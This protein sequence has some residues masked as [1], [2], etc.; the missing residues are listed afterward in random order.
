MPRLRDAQTVCGEMSQLSFDLQGPVAKKSTEPD[1]TTVA[2]LTRRI[3]TLLETDFGDLWVEG[4]ISNMRRQSSGHVYFTLKDTTAQLTC[5]LF[6]GQTPQLRGMNFADGVQVQ[7]FG[8]ISVYEPRGQYQMIV[9]K[10]RECGAGALQAKFE[11]LKKRLAAEG[12]FESA[13]KRPLPK[14]PQRIGVVTSATGAAIRDFLNVLHRRHRG[15]EVVIHPVRVQGRGAA[16]EIARAVEEL[17][18]ADFAGAVDVIVVT[19]GGGSL[20][21]LWEF[22]EEVVARAIA[23]S[24]VP[25]VSAI[26]HEI[27]F[28]IS[29]FVA[30][31]R[32]ATPSA[33][34]E[35]LS[36]DRE[37]LIERI[38]AFRARLMR[39][40]ATRV[41]T[42]RDGI[43]TLRRTALFLEPQRALR[44][45]Q[46]TLDRCQEDLSR[47]IASALVDR[48]RHLDRARSV[49]AARSPERHLAKALGQFNLLVARLST[50]YN[51]STT[52]LRVRVDRAKAVLSSL[53]PNAALARGYTVTLDK[54]GRSIRTASELKRGD[55]LVTKFR[56][57]TA[58]SIVT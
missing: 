15:I 51:K 36:A 19:R 47:S 30:D 39:P 44:E 2:A 31:L 9:R 13:R 41:A 3:R 22:N 48:R 35:L 46:Q 16:A 25:V 49:L 40:V 12:L 37:E 11:E 52:D 43:A 38:E 42:L 21:D 27:D 33:A 45:R 5:V 54:S 20:E 24:P 58:Q 8:S 34:A 32:A 14:F 53:N 4:E 7:V 26:G 6:A 28:T 1:V 56:D 17:G 50:A 18:H 29:D 10:V 23:A 55:L 57:G